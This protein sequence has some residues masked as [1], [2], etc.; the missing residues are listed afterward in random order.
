MP[1]ESGGIGMSV[2]PTLAVVVAGRG[3]LPYAVLHGEPLL[4]HALR[5]AS[6][7]VPGDRVAVL[8]D[9]GGA[10]AGDAAR[11]PARIARRAG[12][13]VEVTPATAFWRR[14]HDA[15]VVLVD[16]LCPLVPGTFVADL[17][18]RAVVNPDLGFVA[19]R[20]V[21][22]TVKSVVGGRIRGTID[23]E[24]LALVS[25]PVVVPARALRD[26]TVPPDE[27]SALVAWLRERAA[28]EL[29]R[30]PSTG[31]R[32]DDQAALDVLECIDEI[33]RRTR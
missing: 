21:T 25:S 23:R 10:P 4:A 22:D 19:Y 7:A 14:T 2:T 5:A 1:P 17:A 12:V 3:G 24:A 26:D 33:A 6:H 18:G 32:V 9:D 29:V 31:R 13:D 27:V 30:A 15:P 16:P 20:P 11:D 28:V 8:T